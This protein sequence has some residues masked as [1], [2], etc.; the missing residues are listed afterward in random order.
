M[1]NVVHKQDTAFMI[2]LCLAYARYVDMLSKYV[3]TPAA[4]KTNMRKLA[5]A[6][7]G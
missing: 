6:N 4:Y 7:V 1:E 3:R 5:V 2:G